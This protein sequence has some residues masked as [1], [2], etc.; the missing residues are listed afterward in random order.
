MY[1]AIS[2]IQPLKRQTKHNTFNINRRFFFL[3]FFMSLA[4]HFNSSKAMQ[5]LFMSNVKNIVTIVIRLYIV[6]MRAF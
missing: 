2:Y 1:V 5:I 6:V 4:R 3:F